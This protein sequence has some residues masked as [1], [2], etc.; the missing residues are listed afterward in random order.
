[1]FFRYY[2]DEIL[3]RLEQL[4]VPTPDLS[5]L[6]DTEVEEL[7]AQ[8][9]LEHVVDTFF[10]QC[11]IIHTL[12]MIEFEPEGYYLIIEMRTRLDELYV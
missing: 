11:P 3:E 5:E 12:Q 10:I 1:M 8:L 6:L 9:W 2:V 7:G 4:V